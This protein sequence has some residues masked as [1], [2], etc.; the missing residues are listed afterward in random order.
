[1]RSCLRELATV[2][3]GLVARKMVATQP[4]VPAYVALIDAPV[5]LADRLRLGDG[6]TKRLAPLNDKGSLSPLF[7]VNAPASKALASAMLETP[8]V[9]VYSGE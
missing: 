2:R 9:L 6:G 8:G 5:A 1:M 7:R 4:G 3:G